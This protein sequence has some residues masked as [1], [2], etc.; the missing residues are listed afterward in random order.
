[1]AGNGN[2]VMSKIATGLAIA[3][4]ASVVLGTV[5]LFGTVR[6]NSN[7]IDGAVAR[8][9][10]CELANERDAVAI[11]AIKGDLQEIKAILQRIEKKVGD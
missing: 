1:M 9:A 8:I 5:T 7:T 6:V 10:K 11:S 3:I 2:G 4:I